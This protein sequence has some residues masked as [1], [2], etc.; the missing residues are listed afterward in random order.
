MRNVGIIWIG[1]AIVSGLN[2]QETENATDH[3]QIHKS[4]G[5]ALVYSFLVPG[6]GELYLEDWKWSEWGSGKTW[7]MSEI[8]MWGTHVYLASYSGWVKDDARALAA[9]RAGVDW[10]VTKPDNYVSNIGKFTDIYSYNDVQ[11][12]FTGPEGNLY[13]E[14]ADNFWSW[15]SKNSQN[16]YD[17]LRIR[18][19]TFKRYSE[20]TLYG[21]F[22][23]HVVSVISAS[24]AFRRH[25]HNNS[26]RVGFSYRP[27][28]PSGQQDVW[29]MQLSRQW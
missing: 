24:R 6:L 8:V 4:R 15:D 19:R 11:R 22:V 17:D 14:T 27:L 29:L 18:S 1:L 28:M 5:T 13:P 26:V 3:V 23:N 25:Q 16:K 7:F 12:R 20:F 21:I 9:T 10:S 2:A